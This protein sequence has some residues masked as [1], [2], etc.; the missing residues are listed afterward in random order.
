MQAGDR[1]ALR[2]AALSGVAGG[3]VWALA[4]HILH[5]LPVVPLR[6]KEGRL[7]ATT[8]GEFH[9]KGPV[10]ADAP[11]PPQ[12]CIFSHHGEILFPFL[13]MKYFSF[14]QGKTSY[15]TLGERSPSRQAVPCYCM[16]SA[17]TLKK[18]LYRSLL[19]HVC[20]TSQPPSGTCCCRKHLVV[21][22]VSRKWQPALQVCS[23]TLQ[24]L[25]P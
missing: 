13:N 22:L 21:W 20:R 4:V 2:W 14:I 18:Q 25:S 9:L 23:E 10:K 24:I 6:R 7:F 12:K 3:R 15:L 17:G 11:P 16:T 8:S 1:P 5:T 19:G